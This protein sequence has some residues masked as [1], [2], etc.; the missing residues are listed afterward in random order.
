M[1]RAS[2]RCSRPRTADRQAAPLRLCGGRIGATL[3]ASAKESLV[4]LL[5]SSVAALVA[6]MV[7]GF[8]AGVRSQTPTQAPSS[9]DLDA[10]KK[11]LAAIRAQQ[12]AMQK[13]ITAIKNLLSRQ[14]G[15]PAGAG[16][17]V[18]PS[19]NITG[20]PSKGSPQ[21]S[22]VMVEF[23]DFQ[24]PYCASY[25][26]SIF[27]QLDNDYIKTGKIRYV[28]K[29]LPLQQIHPQAYQAA[30]AAMC[31]ADQ[32]RF[33]EMHD[34]LFAHQRQ[35]GPDQLEKYASEAGVDKGKFKTCVANRAP[36]AMIREDMTEATQARVGGTPS[37]MLATAGADGVSLVPGRIIIGAQP[38][39]T[40]K[41]ALDSLLANS[42]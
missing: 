24:C 33:W 4:H 18:P 15:A 12:E 23:T 19:L 28:V 16:P 5:R 7:V 37:F 11:E 35:L 32:G 21:A 38:Y 36:E 14:G 22:V 29:N 1:R 40:F 30:I 8:A 17:Q 6:I 13:D 26:A 39:T 42:K 34:R 31:A 9:S 41:S 20:R 2:R 10:I 27:P 25:L 3:F